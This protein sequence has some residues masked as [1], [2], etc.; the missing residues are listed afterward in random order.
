MLKKVLSLFLLFF[1][2]TWFACKKVDIQFGDQFLDN[3]YTQITKVDSFATELS[4]VYVDSFATSAS[5]VA[6]V[7][8][9]TDPVFGKINT[10]SYIEFAPPAFVDSFAGTTFDSIALILQPTG[11]Y[12]GDSTKPVHI[13][14]SRLSQSIAPYDNNV[15]LLYNTNSFT[16]IPTL[17]GMKDVTVRPTTNEPVSIR[18]DDA[19]GKDLLKKH[20]DPN[21]ADTKTLDAFVQYFYGLQISAASNSA[22]VFNCKDSAVLRLYYKKPGLFTENRVLDF[23]LNNTAHQFNHIDIDRSAAVLKNL[24]A[25]KQLASSDINNAAYTLY[26]AGAMVK[27]RFPSVRDIL[28]V[29]SFAKILKATLVIRPVRGSYGTGS[30]MLPSQ[31]RLAITTTLNQIGS[32]IFVYNSSGS[33]E[34]LIGDLTVDELYGENT[35]YTYDITSYLRAVI[36]DATVNENGLLLLPPSTNYLSQF[37]RVVIGDRNN[38]LGKTELNIVYATVQ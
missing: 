30:F 10:S 18:L 37:N 12:V 24:P 32:D 22:M 35:S 4:T 14:V 20:G 33:V 3:G 1:S 16:T 19:F 8:G 6:M 29:P 28:K 31:L 15:T 34:T 7:G 36:T 9:Y 27:M 21:D 11:S 26:T 38:K 2:V 13:E 25:A 17:L 23:T 5:G